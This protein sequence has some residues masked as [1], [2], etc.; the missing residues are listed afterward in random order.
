MRAPLS[1]S[2][3]WLTLSVLILS[4]TVFQLGQARLRN[5]SVPPDEY[6]RTLRALDQY[7]ALA[8]APDE[9]FVPVTGTV[10]PGDAYSD[11]PL[12]IRRLS[13]LGDLAADAVPSDS[14]VYEG[15]LVEAVKRFQSRHGLKPDGRIEATTLGQLNV[16]LCARVRQLELSA[17][18]WRRHPYDP[19]RP[20][21]VLNL[22]EFRL[23]AYGGT[24]AGSDPELEM[25]VVVGK[26]PDHKSPILLSQL[27]A[28]IFRPYWKVPVSIQRNE[29]LPLIRKD[30]AW[31]SANRFELVTPQ[32]EVAEEEKLSEETLEDISTGKLQLRQKPGP[33]NSLGLVKFLFPNEYGVYMHDTA[34]HS[35]FARER[36]DLSHGCIR[37]EKP[38]DLAAWVLREQSD[39]PR[40]RIEEAMQGTEPVSVK[41]KRPIQIV[42]MYS[43]ASVMKN[44][45]VHFFRDIYGEDAVLEKE[46]AARRK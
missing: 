26:A 45:E 28:V 16:P 7:R 8:A 30:P 32:G 38:E 35:L 41:V 43:T 4:C 18:R 3:V 11:A 25:K 27:Q 42:M 12:L 15:E 1:R 39:W 17:E 14:D 29:L 19:T 36:R 2:S 10:K 9:V 31:V 34:A 44:G 22:P 13:L 23:R 40:E 33:K 46:L 24:D 6:E 37:V 21:I 20:A 5:P